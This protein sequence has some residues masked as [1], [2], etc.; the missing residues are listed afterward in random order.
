MERQRDPT[1]LTKYRTFPQH[2]QEFD[3]INSLKCLFQ[4]IRKEENNFSE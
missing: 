1:K 4:R 3:E 2:K